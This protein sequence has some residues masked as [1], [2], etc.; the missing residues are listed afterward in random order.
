[1]SQ[2]QSANS[3]TSKVDNLPIGWILTAILILVIGTAALY[4]TSPF[5]LGARQL[6]IKLFSLR[7]ENVTWFIT[8]SAGITAYLLLWLSTVWGLVIPSKIFGRSLSGDYTFDFHKFISLLSLGFLALHIFILLIDNYLPYTFAQIF[9]PFLSPYRPVWVG[10][11]VIA[12]YLTILVTVTFYMRKR[13]GMKTFRYI[14]YSS[15][16]AY[17][18][19]TA[20]GFFA[21]TDSSLPLAGLMYGGT[22]LVVVFLTAFW[23]LQAWQGR[24]KEVKTLSPKRLMSR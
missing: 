10:I 13:I 7:S 24:R 2:T 19:G 22:F 8:R 12:L 14:H 11:G 21:G 1:M 9:V 18:G 6:L 16:I 15:L 3:R 23:L 17:L 20:H 5:G 4:L